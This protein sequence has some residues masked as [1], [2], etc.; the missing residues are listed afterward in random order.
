MK[1]L[2]ASAFG[3][4][5]CMLVARILNDGPMSGAEAYLAAALGALFVKHLR[6]DTPNE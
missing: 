1:R 5:A 2:F 6:E 4:A 3:S